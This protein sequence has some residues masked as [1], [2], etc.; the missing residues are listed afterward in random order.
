MLK[1]LIG[2]VVKKATT[3]PNS[4]I[5][6]T[7]TK[8]PFVPPTH[9]NP[10]RSSFLS[11]STF[12]L[13]PKQKETTAEESNQIS[14]QQQL[15]AFFENQKQQND[16]L[17]SRSTF[18]EFQTQNDNHQ[19]N[20]QQ[21]NESSFLEESIS[22][23]N[24]ASIQSLV[25]AFAKNGE[26]DRAFLLFLQ[27]QNQSI[28]P[29]VSTY[30]TLIHS[31]AKANDFSRVDALLS[32]MQTQSIQPN[33]FTLNSLVST[34][35]K[36]GMFEKIN[37]LFIESKN[38]NLSQESMVSVFNTL[39][40]NTL[41][42]FGNLLTQNALID[43][44]SQFDSE[45]QFPQFTQEP[46]QLILFKAF[47]KIVLG[48]NQP[49]SSPTNA[50]SYNI[51]LKHCLKSN[52]I[53]AARL[54][55]SE[56]IKEKTTV[57]NVSFDTFIN[58][59]RKLSPAN[60]EQSLEEI[61]RV[62]VQM[63]TQFGF[64]PNIASYSAF[65][66]RLAN[67]GRFEEALNLLKELKEKEKQATKT[68]TNT[69]TTTTANDQQIQVENNTIQQSHQQ[70]AIDLQ[71]IMNVIYNGLVKHKQFDWLSRLLTDESMSIDSISF[72][73][74]CPALLNAGFVREVETILERSAKMDAVLMD[75]ET[76]KSLIIG[77]GNVKGMEPKVSFFFEIVGLFFFI[78]LFFIFMF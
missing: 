33:E 15:S 18:F 57:D 36:L 37:N 56:M 31:F 7:T 11:I 19:N 53:A 25:R 20:Q 14:N 49:S 13:K 77:Y 35:A 16:V 12:S 54:I 61:E 3:T 73:T 21:I 26:T 44:L 28:I 42:Y 71:P 6:T 66:D 59:L 32:M 22:N 60:S 45:F 51:L 27:L 5:T 68:T 29:D 70:P 74:I 65:I 72:A 8:K 67:A 4:T 41:E 34:Y 17:K 10:Q 62:F 40:D 69:T 24:Q 64:T 46:L 2:G 50:I 1:K 43:V 30:T 9:L 63:R 23:S 58:G 48:P 52:Q 39:V 55:F 38:W 78:L 47:Q 75:Q 76:Y